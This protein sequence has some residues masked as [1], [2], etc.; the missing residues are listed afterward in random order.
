MLNRG[1][2]SRCVINSVL[3]VMSF[4]CYGEGRCMT[5]IFGFSLRGMLNGLFLSGLVLSFI[6]CLI[7]IL[8]LRFTH[9][10]L[11]F[12]IILY[13]IVFSL[14]IAETLLCL[15]EIAF[16]QKCHKHRPANP[17]NVE[18]RSRIFPFSGYMLYHQA[19]RGFWSTD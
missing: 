18:Q 8:K 13:N 12:N 9:F 10:K 11:C 19:T 5:E 2:I 17:T 7:F 14:M 4:F 6:V 16:V 1:N 3:F 15:D